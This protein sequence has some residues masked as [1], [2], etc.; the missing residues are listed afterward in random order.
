MQ[1]QLKQDAPQIAPVAVISITY[2]PP[3][4][5]V[6]AIQPQ[7]PL[8]MSVNDVLTILRAAEQQIIADAVIA[9]ARQNQTDEGK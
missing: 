8:Q 2:A 4:G 1:E 5:R 7:F 3:L 9:Q 6:L